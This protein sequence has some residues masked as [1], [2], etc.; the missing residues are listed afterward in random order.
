[1]NNMR[2]LLVIIFLFL[3]LFISCGTTKI[4]EVPIEK[5]KTEYV[6]RQ[7]IDTF[8]K[9]DSTIIIDKGDTVFLEKYKYLYRYINKT[10]TLIKID[11]LTKTVTVE[12]TK[13]VNK[14]KNWQMG[15]MILGGIALAFS[16]YKLI[17]IIKT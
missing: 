11:T 3:F 17:K 1:M 8:V 13:E 16:G 5:I 9:T 14:L 10:D 12:V 15:L 6:D 7:I 4:I 2:K